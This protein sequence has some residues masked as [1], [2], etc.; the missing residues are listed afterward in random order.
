MAK[1]QVS[2]TPNKKRQED[3]T[4]GGKKEEKTR[5]VPWG[6]ISIALICLVGVIAYSNSFNCSFHFDDHL[7]IEENI[8]IR[9][10][11]N[12]KAW[13]GFVPSRPIG[14]LSFALDY[15][16]HRLDVWGYHLVNLAIHVVNAVLVWWLVLLTMS[17]PVMRSQPISRHKDVNGPFCCFALR[18]TSPGDPV[19]DVY[20]AAI[21]FIGHAVLSVVAG[22]VCK[23]Q[24]WGG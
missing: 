9:N 4:G 22:A 3:I 2:K 8:A 17:T 6:F 15:H 21:G 10:L 20:S 13:W 1:R 19:G 14:Y 12:V 23:G 5:H 11:S 16:F 7:N 18:I 24:T